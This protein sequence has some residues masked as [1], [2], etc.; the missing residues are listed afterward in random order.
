MRRFLSALIL[1]LA[2]LLFLPAAAHAR[3]YRSAA[4]P[5]KSTEEKRRETGEFL[6]LLILAGGLGTFVVIQGFREFRACLPRR[7]PVSLDDD[8]DD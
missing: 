6:V 1:I 8:Y 3:T 4:E 5:L 7:Q 2:G